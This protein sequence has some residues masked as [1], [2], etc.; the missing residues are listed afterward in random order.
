MGLVWRIARCLTTS[1]NM[2]RTEQSG[3]KKPAGHETSGLAGAASEGPERP[4]RTAFFLLL[5]LATGLAAALAGAAFALPVA[6]RP[7]SDME[8][9]GHIFA[10]PQWG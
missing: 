10:F 1:D 3:A 4:Y 5:F 8:L 2:R 9:P 6:L 7:P